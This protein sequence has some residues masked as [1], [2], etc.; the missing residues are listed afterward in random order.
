VLSKYLEEYKQCQVIKDII[1]SIECYMEP[2]V[3]ARKYVEKN[4]KFSISKNI[5]R[6]FD[7][8]TPFTNLPDIDVV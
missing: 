2:M 8:Y 7:K 5:L 4:K 3:R 1:N 6:S